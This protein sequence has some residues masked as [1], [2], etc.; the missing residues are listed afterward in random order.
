MTFQLFF[1]S[2]L[3]WFHFEIPKN[4]D[5]TC[6][7]HE[8]WA[9]WPWTLKTNIQT[10]VTAVQWD[11]CSCLCQAVLLLTL[12]TQRQNVHFSISRVVVAYSPLHQKAKQK[13]VLV[14]MDRMPFYTQQTD[15]VVM[16]SAA[17]QL[18]PKDKGHLSIIKKKTLKSVVL[19]PELVMYPNVCDL[20]VFISLGGTQLTWRHAWS[21]NKLFWHRSHFVT[22]SADLCFKKMVQ[23]GNF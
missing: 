10:I 21:W 19:G 4:Q 12:N 18:L 20:H 7:S 8:L 11:N 1:V 9:D 23:M 6:F 16:F 17:L 13:Y 14:V 5:K 15:T 3:M 2:Q 22:Q